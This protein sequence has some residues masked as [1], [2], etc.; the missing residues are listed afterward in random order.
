MLVLVAAVWPWVDQPGAAFAQDESDNVGEAQ[1][2]EDQVSDAQVDEA[3]NESIDSTD[4]AAASN[5][6]PAA[7]QLSLPTGARIAVIEIEGAIFYKNQFDSVVRRVDRAIN[8]GAAMIVFDLDTPGGRMDL[9]IDLS[10]YIRSLSVPTVA[11]VNDRAISAGILIAS[12]CDELVMSRGALAGDCGP[13]TIGRD[14]APSER[15]KALSFL[16]AEFR[17]NAADN[18]AGPT[19][20]DYALFN[21][22]CV[23]GIDVYEVRHRLTG[24]VRLV[25]QA[26]YAVMVEGQTPLDAAKIPA[27][28][29]GQSLV[30]DTTGEDLGKPTVTVGQG[31]IGQWEFVR[32]IHNGTSFVTLT[33]QEALDVGLSKQTVNSLAELEQRYGAAQAKRYGETWSE[34]IVGFLVNPFIRGGLILLGI[35]GLFIEYLSPGLILPGLVG[36]SAIVLAIG[37]PF[38]AGLAET[39]HLVVMVLGFLLIVYELLTMTTFGILAVVGLFMFL[40]GFVLSGVESAA[41]GLPAPGAGRQVVISSMSFVGAILLT[42]P[43]I[44]VITKYFGSIPLFTKLVLNDKLDASIPTASGP[45][46]PQQH[47]EG[48]ASVGAGSIRVGTHAVVSTTGLRP[49]GRVLIDDQPIDV[50]STGGYVDPGT[51]VRVVEVHGNVIHVE[52]VDDE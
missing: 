48:D 51:R 38:L 52:P 14:M 41:N 22:M 45:P 25:S 24:E 13:V 49:G 46:I 4:P 50:T 28:A 6:P 17:A 43:V 40:T 19:T 10:T 20:D 3:L 44:F 15:A 11:W 9:A 5:T 31:E 2:D 42:I 35:I 1:V 16:L 34:S 21:A 8:D 7:S 30:L 26:D 12:A 32:Q 37:A 36:L 29:A 23:L 47:V 27:S 18:Y 33:T 39:W